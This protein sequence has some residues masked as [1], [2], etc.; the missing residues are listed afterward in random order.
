MKIH[1]A[2]LF[3]WRMSK[4]GLRWVCLGKLGEVELGAQR[5]ASNGVIIVP[6]QECKHRLRCCYRVEK[7]N[8]H[9]FRV[10]SRDTTCIP[11]CGNPSS[12]SLVLLLPVRCSVK[13][14]MS[15]LSSGYGM[16]YVALA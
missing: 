2:I 15:G 5:I 14:G 13:I 16:F 10:F 6:P 12:H 11:F 8:I 3:L 7:I 9:D 1:P 4:V